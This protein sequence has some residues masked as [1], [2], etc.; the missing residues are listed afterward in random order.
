MHKVW[1][2]TVATLAGWRRCAGGR[3]P[4]SKRRT[5]KALLCGRRAG[6]LVV[7]SLIFGGK[8]TYDGI[9]V[10]IL[11]GLWM[12]LVGLLPSQS[13]ANTFGEEYAGIYG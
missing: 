11:L 4:C 3:C 13:V 1:S 5:E 8:A 10:A 6:V 2:M 7:I 9:Y 12:F